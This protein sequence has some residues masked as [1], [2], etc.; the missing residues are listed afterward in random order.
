VRD[1]IA[2]KRATLKEMNGKELL[3]LEID[4]EDFQ[5]P[6]QFGFK[7]SGKDEKYFS[8]KRSGL[9][10]IVTFKKLNPEKFDKLVEELENRS[11]KNR[12]ILNFEINVID[13]IAKYED[14]KNHEESMTFKLRFNDYD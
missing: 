5:K 2:G 12:R 9:S 8:T 11:G 6:E 1:A 4:D 3:R 10:L 14:N 13:T 7:L